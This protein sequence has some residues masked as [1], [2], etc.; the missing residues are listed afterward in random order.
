MTSKIKALAGLF[1]FLAVATATLFFPARALAFDFSWSC[2]EVDLISSCTAATDFPDVIAS[3]INL[4][5][6]VVVIFLIII[7]FLIFVR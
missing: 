2:T 6:G 3:Y 4:W 7:I 5:F 1:L